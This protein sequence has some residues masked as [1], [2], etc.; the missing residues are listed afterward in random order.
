MDVP[1]EKQA[2]A[3]EFNIKDFT[4]IDINDGMKYQQMNE[5]FGQK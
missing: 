3:E 2:K 5:S 4:D 1:D